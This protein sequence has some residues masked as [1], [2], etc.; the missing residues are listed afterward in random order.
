MENIT[1]I[2]SLIESSSKGLGTVVELVDGI[3]GESS[4]IYKVE[5]HE[6][7][8]GPVTYVENLRYEE[9]SGQ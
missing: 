9:L 7:A 1:K 6:V 4:A 8:S 3:D 2:G 5:W